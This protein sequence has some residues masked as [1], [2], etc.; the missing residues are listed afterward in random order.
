MK[1]DL[2][3]LIWKPLLFKL[4]AEQAH[5]VSAGALKLAT[6][7]PPGRWALKQIYSAGP[8]KDH[9][10]VVAGIRFPNPIGLAAGFDK[11][12]NS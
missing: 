10:K 4:D 5:F 12:P 11:M 2:Y 8:A 7:F 6:F 3:S 1:T 9:A